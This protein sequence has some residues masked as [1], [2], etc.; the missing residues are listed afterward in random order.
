MTY[1]ASFGLLLIRGIVG[2]VM[3]YHG[4]QKLFPEQMFGWFGGGGMEGFIPAVSDLGVPGV[5]PEILAYA[6]AISEFGGGILLMLGF[7]TRFAGLFI[8]VTMAVAAIK[9][10]GHAFSLQAQGMEYALTLGLVSLGLVFTGPGRFAI[11]CLFRR[12]KGNGGSR[13]PEKKK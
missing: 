3:F 10:H 1:P 6:A 2:F 4:A 9:V 8:A 7:A 13:P 11:D 5:P 12:K